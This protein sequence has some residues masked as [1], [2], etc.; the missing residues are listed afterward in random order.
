M[1]TTPV[2]CTPRMFT[3]VRITSTPRHN[4]RVCGCSEGAGGDERAHAGRNA[5]RGGQDVVDHERRGRQQTGIR[6]QVLSGH[7]VGAAALRIGL[8]GLAVAEVDDGLAE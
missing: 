6:A 1:K 4:P 2:S 3:M 7:G 8:D 5:H